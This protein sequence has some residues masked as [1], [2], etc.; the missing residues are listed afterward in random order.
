MTTDKE[1]LERE[2][3]FLNFGEETE[4]EGCTLKGIYWSEENCLDAM[5]KAREDTLDK[6][7]FR[8]DAMPKFT[9]RREILLL[10]QELRNTEEKKK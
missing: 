6:L 7:Q 9:D 8:I 5:Q 3:D 4:W 1:I 10:I 2:P